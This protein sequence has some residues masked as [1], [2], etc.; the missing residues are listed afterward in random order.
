MARKQQ[1]FTLIELMIVVIIIAILAAIAIPSYA[2]Y[3]TRARVVEATHGLGDARNKME[4]YFR[5]TAHRTGCVI[6]P[7]ARPDP[8]QLEPPVF[9]G[10]RLPRPA[11][12]GHGNRDR[13]HG[14]LQLHHQRAQRPH[15]GLRRHGQQRG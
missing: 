13:P 9:R 4:Q 3:V 6:S 5:T 15:F 8:F 1:G 11:V 7:T 10:L 12:H 14:R 2:D